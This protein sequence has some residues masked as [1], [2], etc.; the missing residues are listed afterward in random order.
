MP[1][2][3]CRS[4]QLTATLSFPPTNH[5]ANGASYTKCDL[6]AHVR[7]SA[8]SAPG[9]LPILGGTRVPVLGGVGPRG[10]L[11]ARREATALGGQVRQWAESP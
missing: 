11:R 8:G 10:E 2:S 5:F 4:T 9:S 6:R 1:A 7:R 3:T